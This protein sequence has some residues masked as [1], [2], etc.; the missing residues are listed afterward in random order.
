MCLSLRFNEKIENWELV[1]HNILQAVFRRMASMDD[2][3]FTEERIET[4]DS[5]L[6]QSGFRGLWKT[7]TTERVFDTILCDTIRCDT[8][9]FQILTGDQHTN[10][11]QFSNT[12]ASVLKIQQT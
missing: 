8:I 11:W 10:L 12:Q 1:K 9:I 2:W 6:L 5:D 7:P 3:V 4:W